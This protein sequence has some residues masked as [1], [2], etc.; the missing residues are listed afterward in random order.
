[1]ISIKCEKWKTKVGISLMLSS[2]G[3]SLFLT[4]D[5]R[6]INTMKQK[7][8]WNNNNLSNETKEGIFLKI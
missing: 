7:V 4:K 5:S 1:M 8:V 3:E 6:N 2:Q